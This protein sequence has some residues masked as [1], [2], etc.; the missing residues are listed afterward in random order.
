MIGPAGDQDYPTGNYYGTPARKVG[1]AQ[2]LREVLGT[3]VTVDYEKGADFVGPADPEAVARAVALA[4]RADV[5][6]LCL[7]TNLQTE[8]EGRDRRDL[9]LPGAQQPLLEA[10]FA[11]TR[12]WC[13]SSSMPGRSP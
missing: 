12:R 11:R 7:G 10:V 13:S 6:I 3:G 9:N 4:K 2:G 5:V 8:A 1:V